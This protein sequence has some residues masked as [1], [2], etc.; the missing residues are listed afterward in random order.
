MD[1]PELGQLIAKLRKAK[2]LTQEE[3]VGRCKLSVRTL[4]RIESGEVMPRSFTLKTIFR[5][6]DYQE[7]ETIVKH[8]A[9]YSN[10][11]RSVD[12]WLLSLLTFTKDLFNLKTKPMR[13]IA[14]LSLPI[15]AVCLLLVFV[16]H[17]TE[18]QNAGDVQQTIVEKNQ[19]FVRWF[20]EG[21]IDSLLTVYRKDA[22]LIAVGCGLATIGEYYAYQTTQFTFNELKTLS[23]SVCDSIAV[24]KGAWII[25]LNESGELLR[26][27]YLSEWRHSNGQWLMVNDIGSVKW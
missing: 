11:K 26:G 15:A 1:Q 7:D 20:N 12:P 23:V 21:K 19:N 16:C 4:Q 27:E 18:A 10:D 6:L 5:E 9:I 8:A 3:L 17:K 2:G 13:K 24:E 22:C 14:I 25:K